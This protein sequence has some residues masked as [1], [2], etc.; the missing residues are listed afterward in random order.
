MVALRDAKV[1]DMP[2][3][4]ALAVPKRVDVNGEAVIA[5][6]GIGISFGDD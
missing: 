3:G 2:L 4:E 5:A 1:V 6:R